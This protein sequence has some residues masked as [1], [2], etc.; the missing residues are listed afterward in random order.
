MAQRISG[1]QYGYVVFVGNMSPH[2]T[3]DDVR[4]MVESFGNVESINVVR[5]QALDGAC[6]FAF[7]KMTDER[8]AQRAIAELSGKSI[9]G[10]CLNV[11]VL[12]KRRDCDSM[13]L[14]FNLGH[15]VAR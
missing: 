9:K 12:T 8:A 6:G 5:G 11:R 2:L 4:V 10:R 3:E 13:F 14:G 15:L 7:V 1:V